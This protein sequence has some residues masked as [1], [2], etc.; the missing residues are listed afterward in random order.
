MVFHVNQCGEFI[1]AQFL[2]AVAYIHPEDEICKFTLLV[3]HFVLLFHLGTQDISTALAFKW[4]GVIGKITEHVKKVAILH[5]EEAAHLFKF[6]F[7]EA[8][9]I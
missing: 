8:R 1:H 5:L 3:R 7:R 9:L 6:F 2:E 4:R